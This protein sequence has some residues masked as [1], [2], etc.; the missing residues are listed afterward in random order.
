[1]FTIEE[2]IKATEGRLIKGPARQAIDGIST[3][4]RTV[5]NGELFVALKGIRFDGHF[6]IKDC[7]S[8][9]A[10]GLVVSEDEEVDV[11]EY[12]SVIKVQD[13]LKA[14]G[15]IAHF[16]RMRFDIPIVAVTGSNGKTTTKDMI[17]QALGSRYKVLKSQG[18]FNNLIGVPITLLKL[19]DEHQVCV[20]EM[21]TSRLGEIARLA[22]IARPNI[23]VITNVGPSHLEFFKDLETVAQAKM[24]LFSGFGKDDIAIWNADDCMLSG[25]YET[26]I[27]NKRTFGLANGCDF[28]A[29]NIEYAESGWRFALN[30]S[31]LI[32]IRLLGQHN[33]HNALAAIAVVETLGIE[34]QDIYTALLNFS[35]PPM[36][37]EILQ[38]GGVTIINDCYNSN[39][40]SMESA[41]HVLSGFSAAGRKVLVSG[42]MLE[43]GEISGYFHHQLGLNVA[44]SGIDIFIGVGE[45][46]KEATVS[47]VRAGMNGD[48]V[49][50]CKDS[51]EAGELLLKIL[52]SQ[53]VV[54]IKGSRAMNME[55][56]CSTI[57]SIP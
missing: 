56:V 31:K 18:T 17:A 38:A 22:K 8:R 6:F 5:N 46:S 55:K 48:C 45:R 49:F 20:L 2:I 16:H 30:Q 41:I 9:G 11:P 13:S 23:G 24:E 1:M 36:R 7:I 14:L 19:N 44:E 51:K 32:K 37:M 29:T 10:L 54:L 52:H 50:F 34:Y 39:P 21:G 28:Q 12:V 27:C 35:T 42:D 25:L 43:L 26:L 53:D 57:Y 40:K 4:S 3:D 15:D 47:A 33:V